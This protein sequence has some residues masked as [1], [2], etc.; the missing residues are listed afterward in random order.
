MSHY[1]QVE[2]GIVAQVIVAE[3]DHIDTLT[4]TWVQTSYNTRGGVHY[5]SDGQP[6]NGAQFRYNFAGIGSIY[7]ST[8]DAFYNPQP[9]PSWTLSTT[10]YTWEAPT[11]MPIDGTYVWNE[12]TTS[13]TKVDLPSQENN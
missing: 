13:W 6:D 9:Y 3:Q 12:T 10:S 5:G 8:A 1:A 2:N 7:D 4:G 11:P